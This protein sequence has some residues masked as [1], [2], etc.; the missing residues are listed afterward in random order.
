MAHLSR[1]LGESTAETCNTYNMLKL[2]RRLFLRDADPARIDFYE[3]GLF[4]HILASQDPATGD[5]DL[6]RRP[7][8][9]G[10]AHLLDPGGLVLVLRGDGDGEPGPLR[11]GHLRA[12][13]RRP[14]RQPLPRL[15]AHVAGEGPGGPPG[16]PLPRRGP[17]AARAAPREAG[18]IRP[19][20][21]P[22]GVG[23]GRPRRDRERAGA[24]GRQ[25]ARLVRDGRAR[26]ARRRRGRGAPAH[27]PAVRG[28]IRRPRSWRLPLRPDRPRG[29]PRR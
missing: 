4:N 16:D 24:G 21:A 14:P 11:R 3:R 15:R 2:S 6:L 1:H 13:G 18:P 19:A 7:R 27:E 9:G 8:A 28:H 23:E 20:P 26:V 5:G 10:V 17:D 12:T 25:P 22:P 29:R